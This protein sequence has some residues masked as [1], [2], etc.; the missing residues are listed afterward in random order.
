MQSLVLLLE[1]PGLSEGVYVCLLSLRTPLGGVTV[2]KAVCDR[3][4]RNA[5]SFR[6]GQ[7]P[8]PNHRASNW[9]GRKRRY[10]PARAGGRILCCVMSATATLVKGALVEFGI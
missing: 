3:S 5:L 2:G 1:V 6:L 9:T 7:A 4:R 8:G 10:V